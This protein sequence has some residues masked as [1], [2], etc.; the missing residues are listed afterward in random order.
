MP[1]SVTPGRGGAPATRPP[2]AT[3][4]LAG[5]VAGTLDAT[6]ACV[7]FVLKTGRNPIRVFQF[8]ATGVFGRAALTGGW[9]MALCGVLFHYFIAT[10]WAAGYYLVYPKLPRLPAFVLGLAYGV[11]VWAGM[12]LVVVPLSNVPGRPLELVSAVK[13]MAILMVCVGLPIALIVGRGRATRPSV[14]QSAPRQA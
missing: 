12:N 3:I 8:I 6:A 14:A 7:D 13:S 2:I 5:L 9:T 4:A 11:V 1:T 10:S